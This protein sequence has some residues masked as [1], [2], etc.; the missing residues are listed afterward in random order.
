LFTVQMDE[1]LRESLVKAI[2]LRRMASPV[3]IANTILFFA[4]P[5]ADYI[6]GQVLSVSGGLTMHG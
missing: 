5:A 4:S 2:P 6:T 3:E 1:K